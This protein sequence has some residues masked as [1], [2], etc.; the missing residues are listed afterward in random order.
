MT[1]SAV[2]R[3]QVSLRTVR[4]A[5]AGLALLV[6]SGSCAADF[7]DVEADAAPSSEATDDDGLWTRVKN[8]P[9]AVGAGVR[10]RRVLELEPDT[11][12]DITFVTDLRWRGRSSGAVNP[13]VGVALVSE[14]GE[15]T[16]LQIF[17]SGGA[18]R[19]R[20][21]LAMTDALEVGVW[22]R[23]VLTI[24]DAPGN[25]VQVRI[26]EEGGVEVWRSCDGSGARCP[27][28]QIDDEDLDTLR[29]NVIVDDVR[30]GEGHV[31]LKDTSLLRNQ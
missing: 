5:C 14:A 15:S 20:V 31:E 29:L 28:V 25:P 18:L 10:A 19:A 21:D 7:D 23:V 8:P 22:Y 24:A 3:F 4:G 30:D 17:E 26:F 12:A 1:R 6:A 13:Q 27:S 2:S 9:Y 11:S 16:L